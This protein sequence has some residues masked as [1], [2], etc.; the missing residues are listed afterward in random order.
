MEDVEQKHKSKAAIV[1]LYSIALNKYFN[2]QK[3]QQHFLPL[4]VTLFLLGNIPT[5]VKRKNKTEYNLPI[6]HTL[7][8]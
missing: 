1:Q 5:D 4:A 6:Y 2:L 7:E 3:R 8:Q